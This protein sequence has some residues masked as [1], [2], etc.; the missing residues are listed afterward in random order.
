LQPHLALAPDAAAA[1]AGGAARL[2][3]VEGGGVAAWEAG[4]GGAEAACG[5]MGAGVTFVQV[6]RWMGRGVKG[7]GGGKRESWVRK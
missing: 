4:A 7:R 3:P 6:G 2:V 1:A 5:D